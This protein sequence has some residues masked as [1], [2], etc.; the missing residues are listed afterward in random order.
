MITDTRGIS[1]TRHPWKGVDR[2]RLRPDV[3]KRNAPRTGAGAQ[4]MLAEHAPQLDLE[5]LEVAV[6]QRPLSV[7][8]MFE[9]SVEAFAEEIRPEIGAV[10]FAERRR[11]AKDAAPVVGKEH[12]IGKRAREWPQALQGTPVGEHQT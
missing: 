9:L 5:G 1:G 7:P 6:G 8:T 11:L 12:V 4:K 10:V 3:D 2:K